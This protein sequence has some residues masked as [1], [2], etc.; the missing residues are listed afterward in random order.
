M[1]SLA[2]LLILSGIL[3]SLGVLGFIIRRNL[4]I[5]FM[6]VELILNSANLALVAFAY[7]LGTMEPQVIAVFVTALAA[8]EAAVGLAIVVAVYKNRKSVNIDD[9][10]LLKW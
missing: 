2:E 3:F 7:K 8:A 10:N 9:M 4:L 1:M 6:A 5:M